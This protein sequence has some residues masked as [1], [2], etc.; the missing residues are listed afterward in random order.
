MTAAN[1]PITAMNAENTTARLT[2]N[3]TP[4]TMRRM[5]AMSPFHPG[6]FS[7]RYGAY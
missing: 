6:S 5:L 3:L 4:N 2:R 7:P 1:K